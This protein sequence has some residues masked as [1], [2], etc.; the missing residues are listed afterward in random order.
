ME[1]LYTGHIAIPIRIIFIHGD[2]W[3]SS[4]CFLSSIEGRLSE[5]RGRVTS[6]GP[7]SYHTVLGKWGKCT[8]NIDPVPIFITTIILLSER[9]GCLNRRFLGK[10]NRGI[11]YAYV[12]WF[13]KKFVCAQAVGEWQMILGI[14]AVRGYMGMR[15]GLRDDEVLLDDGGFLRFSLD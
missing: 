3:E 8:L 13:C 1:T 14:N 9:K 7:S 15:D 12:S 10:R 6:D 4:I 5:I 2:L 11:G